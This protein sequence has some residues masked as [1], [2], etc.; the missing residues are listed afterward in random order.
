MINRHIISRDVINDFNTATHKFER[1]N[2]K[3][4]DSLEN[5]KAVNF[6]AFKDI[7]FRLSSYSLVV[8]NFTI[9][10][11]GLISYLNSGVIHL[12]KEFCSSSSFKIN[13]DNEEFIIESSSSKRGI[14]L[15]DWWKL[16]NVALILRNDTYK[17]ELYS[18]L[19]NCMNETKDPFW[20]KSMMLILMCNDKK[21]FDTSILSEIKSIVKSGVVEYYNL[22][23]TGLIK[24]NEGKEKR[25]KLWIPIMELYYLAYLND[26]NTFNILLKEYLIVKKKWI[27][28][29]KEEDNSSYWIDFPLLACCSYAHDKNISIVVESEYIPYFVFKEKGIS[30]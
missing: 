11:K 25:E 17:E 30:S 1:F 8:N 14:D 5:N 4:K 3:I 10:Y 19:S 13:F 24:S 16:F 28:E 26:T 29:N 20:R 7:G 27:I 9:A 12:R 18:L 15:F 22:Q 23:G 21:E 2:R 6:W